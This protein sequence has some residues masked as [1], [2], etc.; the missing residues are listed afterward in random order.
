MKG[1][2]FDRNVPQR[3]KF[4]PALPIIAGEENGENPSDSE[5]WNFAKA[6]DLVIVSKDADFSERII[7]SSP[8]PKVV[9]L[10]LGNLRKKQF[11][12]VLSRVWPKVEALLKTH[13]LVNVFLDRIEAIH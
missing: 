11:H 2:Y 5:V 13:K 8:P 12:E 10:K 1:Y 9:H 7:V 4:T 6:N 3:L